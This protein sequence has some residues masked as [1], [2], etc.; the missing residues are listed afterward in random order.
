MSQTPWNACIW[1]REPVAAEAPAFSQALGGLASE[2]HR[3]PGVEKPD[4]EYVQPV[5]EVPVPTS[6]DPH[7]CSLSPAIWGTS[8]SLQDR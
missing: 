8:H 1:V 5:P 3:K 6:S 4:A 2:A 7:V